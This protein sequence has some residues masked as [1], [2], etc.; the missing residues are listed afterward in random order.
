MSEELSVSESSCSKVG[1]T[2]GAVAVAVGAPPVD[3]ADPCVATY[4]P[5]VDE[6]DHSASKLGVVVGPG[7]DPHL[8][9]KWSTL[10]IHISRSF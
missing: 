5:A 2:A 7:G 10:S 1:G 9:A 8:E 4:A 3:V 6:L